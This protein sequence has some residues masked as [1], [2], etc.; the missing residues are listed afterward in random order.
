MSGITSRIVLPDPAAEYRF[1]AADERL[2]RSMAL[3]TGGEWRPSAAALRNEGSDRRTDR[4]PIWQ[5]FVTVGLCLWFVDIVFRR[6]RVFEP[7]V[8]KGDH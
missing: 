2:L 7:V 4:R 8:R 6:I 5:A 1:K 3:A